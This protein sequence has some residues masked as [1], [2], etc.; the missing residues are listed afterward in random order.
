[1]AGTGQQVQAYKTWG[2][3]G[4]QL[5]PDLVD[6]SERKKLPKSHQLLF[7]QSHVGGHQGIPLTSSILGSLC[8]CL[9][10]AN[11][12]WIAWNRSH[13]RIKFRI[14]E[15]IWEFLRNLQLILTT[16]FYFAGYWRPT[17]RPGFLFLS[18]SMS[19][20]NASAEAAL[21]PWAEVDLGFRTLG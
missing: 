11:E 3:K 20:K 18:P 8:C 5:S 2:Q 10:L 13:E 6:F 14:F 12:A 9:S 4:R 21:A 7:P 1:M 19:R 17:T 16:G 15:E